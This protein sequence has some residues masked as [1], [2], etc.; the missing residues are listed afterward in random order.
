LTVPFCMG[1]PRFPSVSGRKAIL[2]ADQSMFG[3]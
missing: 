3:E 1:A 2:T